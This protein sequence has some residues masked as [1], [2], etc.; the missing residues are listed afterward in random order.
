MK[1]ESL[2]VPAAN[3]SPKYRWYVLGVL[4]LL[5]L[6]SQMDRQLT[7]VLVTPLKHSFDISDTQFGLLHG[8]AFALTYSV[9]A[10]PFG[11]LVDRSNRRNIITAGVLAW[12][13]LTM[14]V[15]FAS[16]FPQLVVLRLGVGIGEAVL[17]PAAYSILAD[18]FEPARRGRAVA[19]YYMALSVGAGTSLIVGGMLLSGLP[20]AGLVLGGRLFAPWQMVFLCAGLPGL[21]AT[22]LAATIR[23]PARQVGIKAAAP[24]LSSTFR[25]IG[26]HRA[27]LARISG[28]SAIMAM[29]GYGAAAWMPTLFERRFGILPGQSGPWIGWM[30]IVCSITGPLLSGWLS[31]R[32]M[33]R[34]GPQARY[35]VLR[36]ASLV[37]VPATI[38]S[39]MPTPWLSFGVC[40]AS[41]FAISMM[42]AAV[43]LVLQEAVPS[44][45]RGQ[46]VALQYLVL[47][48]VG[49]GLGPAAVA[50]VTDYAFKSEAMLPWSL[51]TV[52]L[53]A[54]LLGL[55]FCGTLVKLDR[56]VASELAESPGLAPNN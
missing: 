47:G 41:V 22:L 4:C 23:E 32:W 10:I 13:L 20:A 48:L 55:W 25:H 19:I 56:P 33:V 42:Q 44:E 18:Y 29:I 7:S 54:S 27:V 6:L 8:F 43:P 5:T 46:I 14:G 50:F 15:A 52:G 40:A 1:E 49:F 26:L 28:A 11:L 3:A 39:L 21:F 17:G 38:W 2:A 31:D 34:D 16:S 24:S 36:F 37:M 30:Y 12:S 51:A 45:M 35:R 9:F 53:P